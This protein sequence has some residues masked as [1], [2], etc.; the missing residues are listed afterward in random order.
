MRP[1]ALLVL[2]AVAMTGCRKAHHPDAQTPAAPAMPA[3]APENRNL[4]GK[5]VE[6]I[7]ASP[8]SYLRLET[9]RGEVWAAVPET[10]VEKGAD[11]TVFNAMQMNGFESKTLKR[12][13]DL[14]FFGTLIPPAAATAASPAPHPMDANAPAPAPDVKVDKATG[15]EARTVAEI[16][17]QKAALKEKSVI[18]RGQVVKYNAAVMGKNWVH[19][20]DGS[21][22]PGAG[23]N[24][25][26]VTS[27]DTVKVGEVVQVKGIVR[28]DK[29][30]GS[31]YTYSVIV[32]E[33]KISK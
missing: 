31:G 33:A 17:A 8:Y 30:F 6:R 9:S 32:E 29:D 23:N 10:K 25:L 4:P 21:G 20:H 12:T 11:V 28:T 16:Y 7:D 5:V 13:F 18:V 15:P 27:Q 3:A 1:L 19:L 22:T 2:T 14:I 26:T 24:D